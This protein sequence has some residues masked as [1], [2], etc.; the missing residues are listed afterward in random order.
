[1]TVTTEQPATTDRYPTRG[2]SAP[3]L[4]RRQEPSVWG[5]ASDGPFDAAALDEYQ[6][7]GFLTLEQ[8]IGP[9]EVAAYTAEMRRL[10]LDPRFIADSRTVVER[11][12]QEVRCIFEVHKISEI[13]GALANHP[14]LVERA[15]QILGSEVYVHQSRVNYK[16]GFDG[17]DFFWHSDFETWHAQ[18]GMPGMRALG[19]SIA[20]TDNEVCNGG[21][22]LMPGSHTTFVSCAGR[23]TS[24][25]YYYEAWV[26]DEIGTPDPES[27]KQLSAEHG[28]HLV[29]GPAGNATMFDSNCMHGSNGNITPY[30]RTSI[31]IVYNSVENALVEPYVAASPRP[32]FIAARDFTPATCGTGI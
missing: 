30:P 3:S 16:P 4:L 12:T 1:M 20:L 9:A 8:L 5:E 10:A 18:D 14:R 27:L 19:I 22:M 17:T 13:F 31:F 32:D 6:T 28:I 21:L 11:D 24:D 15:R 7:N 25:E 26:G 23:P 2:E 29:T